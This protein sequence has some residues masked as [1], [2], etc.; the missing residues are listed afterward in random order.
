MRATL[1]VMRPYAV[2]LR[3]TKPPILTSLPLLSYDQFLA[4]NFF[5][6]RQIVLCKLPKNIWR[7]VI[8]SMA[9]NI[10][11][12]CYPWP[13][14]LGSSLLYV[15]GEMTTRFGNDLHSALD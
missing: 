13:R 6:F 4:T 9:K 15:I 1:S 14:N 3:N 2:P 7:D 10:A 8:V 11:D 12:P 5:D